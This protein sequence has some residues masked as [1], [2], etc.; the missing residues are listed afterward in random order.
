M[1]TKALAWSDHS[2]L[3]RYCVSVICCF[4][5]LTTAAT[6]AMASVPDTISLAGE[7][8]FAIDKDTAE[9]FKGEITAGR[10]RL[11][12]TMDDAGLGKKNTAKPTLSGPY[13][14]FNHIGPAWYQR[15]IEIPADWQEKRVTLLLE[16]ARWTTRLWLDDKIIGSQDSL[17][18]PHVYDLGTA[19]TP[20]KHRLTLCIDNTLKHDLGRFVS[21]LAGGVP[22]NM[23]GV[24]GRIELNAT[25]PVWIDDV[26]VYPD[27]DR[28][29][30]HVKVRLGNATGQAG[31]GTLVIA[32]KN[33]AAS[34]DASPLCSVETDV[35][36]SG[37]G[38][39]D[40][41]APNLTDITVRMGEQERTVRFGMRKFTAEGTQFA[42]NGRKLFLRG[43]LECQVFP[44]TG[45]A[46]MA[47]TEWQR[48]FRIVKSYG[49]N[50]MRFHSWSP[51]EAAFAAADI[52]GVYLQPEAP[53]AN[54]HAGID[55]KRDAFLEAE[56]KRIVDTYG[57]H[58]SFCLMT[59]GNEYSDKSADRQVTT[60]WLDMLIGRDPR[61]LYSSAAGFRGTLTANSQWMQ[62]H[63]GRGVNSQGND[64]DLRKVVAKD[65]RPVVGHEIGQWVFFPDFRTIAKYT[66]VMT[67][68]NFEL[69]RDDM[70]RKHLLDQAEFFVEASGKFAV[71]LYKEEVEKLIRT[72]GYAGFSLLDL[73]DY[74]TQGTALIGPLDEFW[75]NKG[76][77]TSERFRRFC[78]PTVPIVRLTKRTFSSE[79]TLQAAAELANFG[80]ADLSGIEPVWKIS[81]E[82]NRELAS[83]KLPVLTAHTGRLT[84]LGEIK[85]PLAKMP[86][87]AKL[88]LTLSIPG[89]D[90]A[91]DWD[92][93]VYPVSSAANQPTP[94]P[95]AFVCDTWDQAS[96]A[97]KEGRTVLFFSAS[98]NGENSMAGKFLPVFWSPVWFASQRPNTHGLLMDPAHPMLSQFPTSTHSDWQ[99]YELMNRSRV[100]ILDE[101]PAGYRPILQVIDNYAR[102]HKLGVIFEGRVGSGRL[103]VCGLDLQPLIQKHDPAARQMLSG[104]YNYIAS[105]AFK[106]VQEITDEQM[107]KMF[108]LSASNE[109]NPMPG[110]VRLDAIK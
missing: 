99:W 52:E 83:G 38:L 61:H 101:L 73:H 104:I 98:Q 32:G 54:V 57:N 72:P 15:D 53:V 45:Y 47:V 14:K 92:I 109:G 80:P 30:A 86:S 21:A 64:G 40:E 59:I 107:R 77:I 108:V 44:L 19:V 43:T 25:P 91:N 23:N 106:P 81:E 100:Y 8:R 88:T 1:T 58:P 12:G 3:K 6:H 102:N 2:A 20:G 26:Q 42:I 35:G 51:P 17:I 29:L 105:P 34:W 31:Q 28:K 66:G 71:R 94:P 97:L 70:A 37:V 24:I 68:K 87:P 74:P 79:E 63:D 18:A 69:I 103:L 9:L 11:P 90:C 41:F 84:S 5:L 65:A 4:M 46:P 13:R 95:G 75:D 55:P 39:W 16:R 56:L 60:G 50:F 36:M 62:I 7:W 48:I 67:L 85:L 93:W 76:F 82:G 10:I 27:V 33:L 78:G 110:P 96:A 22:N 89:T 49:L